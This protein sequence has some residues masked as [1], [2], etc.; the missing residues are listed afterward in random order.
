[1]DKRKKAGEWII[2]VLTVCAVLMLAVPLLIGA[3][4]TYSAADDF[5]VESGSAYLSE[6][7]GPVRGPLY[8]AW[9]YFMDW[10]G[11]YTTNLFLFTIMP[12]SRFGLD[13][14]RAGMV[15]LSLFFLCSLYFMVNAVINY[16]DGPVLQSDRHCCWNKKLFLYAVLLFATLGLPGTW[17]EKNCFTGIR[18]L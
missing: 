3:G 11:A 1:M 15:I 8:A 14:F 5:I 17:G 16:S 9:N 10:Q 4:Y 7:V 13:G 2:T 18:R 12:F 6:S